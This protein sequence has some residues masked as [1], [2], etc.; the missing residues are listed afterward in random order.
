M[1]GYV[2]WCEDHEMDPSDESSA[3]LFRDGIVVDKQDHDDL[4]TESP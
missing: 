3:E 1:R 4:S 2:E